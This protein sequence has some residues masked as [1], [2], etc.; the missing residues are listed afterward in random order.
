VSNWFINARVRLWKP[1]VEEIHMLETK[2][3][4]AETGSDAGKTNGMK[5]AIEGCDQANKQQVECSSISPSG[6]E[7]DRLNA[8][9]WNQEK[10]SRIEYHVPSS[11]DGSLM[12]LV[13]SHRSGVE[14]GGLGAVSL[15]LGLR[16][17]AENAQRPSL[18]QEHH[19][20]PHF[21]G[22]IIR[23]FVG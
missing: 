20:R 2:G 11:V 17:S 9:T 1:M 15:T 13:P 21:G 5:V 8:N 18:Q 16:Q 22:H 6:R 3:L 19:L 12:G 23:D 10:R 4:A 14:F 7:I